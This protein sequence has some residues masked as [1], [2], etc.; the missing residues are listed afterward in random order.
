LNLKYF[1]SQIKR[2]ELMTFGQFSNLNKLVAN[3]NEL[4]EQE[5]HLYFADYSSLRPLRGAVWMRH[6]GRCDLGRVLIGSEFSINLVE[7]VSLDSFTTV[8]GYVDEGLYT[9]CDEISQLD[10]SRNRIML[11]SCEYTAEE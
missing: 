11:H 6:R 2:G 8:I 5:E 10:P 9:V 3:D 4:H 7:Q 1:F